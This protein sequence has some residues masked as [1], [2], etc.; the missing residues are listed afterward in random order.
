[1]SDERAEL[2]NLNEVTFRAEAR[3][4][5]GTQTWEDYLEDVLD[6]TFVLRR[7]SADRPDEDKAAM[8]AAVAG[9]ES[10]PVRT[11]VPDSVRLWSSGSLG[12][13]ASTVT[14][15]VE[16][17]TKAFANVKIFARGSDGSW[18]CVLWQA[19]PRPLP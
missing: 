9:A 14:L 2:E 5:V 7:S 3:L 4:P 16:G 1:V 12:V 6:E 17:E 8:I 18:R 10:P 19:S 13:V 15:P 11:L